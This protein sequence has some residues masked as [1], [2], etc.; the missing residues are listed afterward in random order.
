MLDPHL[1][2]LLVAF[3]LPTCPFD[4]LQFSSRL[5]MHLSAGYMGMSVLLPG[6]LEGQQFGL[7]VYSSFMLDSIRRNM[8]LAIVTTG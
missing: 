8:L 3:S 1:S 5:P 7:V 4:A 2:W 6:I